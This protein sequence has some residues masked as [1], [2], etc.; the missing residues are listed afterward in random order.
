MHFEPWI[1][2]KTVSWNNRRKIRPNQSPNVLKENCW[3]KHWTKSSA[4][5]Q[6]RV[7]YH[8]KQK[9][10]RLL[11]FWRN[12]TNVNGFQS[13]AITW[14]RLPYGNLDPDPW[15]FPSGLFGKLDEKWQIPDLHSCDMKFLEIAHLSAFWACTTIEK[16]KGWIC[17]PHLK[18]IWKNTISGFFLANANVPKIAMENIAISN[19]SGGI[20]GCTTPTKLGPL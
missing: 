14:F 7:S 10:K 9:S 3:R 20:V 16:L 4:H 8:W 19:E 11:K 6:R 15:P 17:L 1:L 13:S 18:S 12:K 5:A 2:K